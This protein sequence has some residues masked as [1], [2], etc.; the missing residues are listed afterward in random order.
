MKK[1]KP[2]SE[3]V[4]G[5]A[6][7]ALG[8]CVFVAAG[9]LQKVRLG[10]GPGGFPKFISVVLMILGAAQTI[11]AVSAGVEAPKFNVEKKAA[12]LFLSAVIVT[13][14]YVALL[15]T[16]GFVLLT[17][18]LMLI[19][20]YLFG[21]REYLRMIIIAVVTTIVVWLLFTDVFMIFLPQGWFY[22]ERKEFI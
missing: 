13:A 8:I 4:I 9:S 17:P 10:I 19:M 21:A 7:I 3:L 16:V 15:P 1:K 20:M 11:M 22:V 18:V 12:T 5:L 14:V 6:C 2:F